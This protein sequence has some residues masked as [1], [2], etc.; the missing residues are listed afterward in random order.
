MLSNLQNYLIDGLQSVKSINSEAKRV[1]QATSKDFYDW[2]SEYEWTDSRHYITSMNNS[3]AEMTG[4]NNVSPKRFAQ[5]V[6]TYLSYKS[7]TFT[8]GRG[9]SGIF[10]HIQAPF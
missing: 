6:R 2:A 4:N 7:F 9:H 3:F 10:V 1:I 5:Y 8:E